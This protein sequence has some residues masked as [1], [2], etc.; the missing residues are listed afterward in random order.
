MCQGRFSCLHNGLV[1]TA[2]VSILQEDS[3]AGAP[4]VSHPNQPSSSTAH[5][6]A[7]RPPASSSEPTAATSPLEAATAVALPED[8]GTVVLTARKRGRPTKADLALRRQMQE[9]QAATA[10]A[11]EVVGRSTAAV[12]GTGSEAV[13]TAATGGGKSSKSSKPG[14][15][16]TSSRASDA[17]G[18]KQ[19]TAPA[20]ACKADREAAK[21]ESQRVASRT[22]VRLCSTTRYVSLV[23]ASLGCFCT[24]V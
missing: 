7:D 18:K 11:V 17:K 14:G 22:Q 8:A 24:L 16:A 1:L 5:P 12:A 2:H 21:A 15:K 10:T 3:A 20:A 19:A 9:E 13:L 6:P 23:G 4:A